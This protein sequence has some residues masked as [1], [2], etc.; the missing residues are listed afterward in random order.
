M[1]FPVADV[2]A[3]GLVQEPLLA[4][5]SGP[6]QAQHMPVEPLVGAPEQPGLELERIEEAEVPLVP[7]AESVLEVQSVLV[8]LVPVVHI[9]AVQELALLRAV[10][11]RQRTHAPTRTDWSWDRS[12]LPFR[13]RQVYT[14]NGPW[15]RAR[16]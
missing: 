3:L 12:P 11:R 2:V 6:E 1:S 8:Q 15:T 5:A 14:P 7:E 16:A 4:P 10:V 13:H 9:A